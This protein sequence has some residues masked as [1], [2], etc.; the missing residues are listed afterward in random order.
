[1]IRRWLPCAA[2]ALVVVSAAAQPGPAARAMLQQKEALVKRLLTDSPAVVRIVA[3]GNAQAQEYFRL[4]RERH[5]AALALLQ[6]GDLAQAELQLNEA[7][8]MAGKARQ[9][10]PDP[11]LRAI[12]VRVQNRAL[13]RSIESLRASYQ[14]HLARAQGLPRGSAAKDARLAR[15]DARLEEAMSYSSSE[16]VRE[17]NAI[18]HAVERDLMGA[19]AQV[20]G[21][22]TVEYAQ[23][24]E[25]QAEEYAHELARNRSYEELLPVARHE[26]RPG[27]EALAAMERH[28]GQ[29]AAFVERAAK[30]AA[31]REHAAAIEA[32]RHA[33]FHLQS[34]L[35]AA[36]VA[37]PSDAGAVAQGSSR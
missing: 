3:S 11:M 18:L 13:A 32:L 8:W 6:S 10:V 30:S 36:G 19:L 24:F 34:A 1:M 12:E 17:A 4:A 23:R 33:T 28:A 16:H 15:I 27:P 35:A 9:L 7:M 20:L 22:D 26:L 21:S 37:L 25:T 2:T 14:A 5:D 29:S 31:R